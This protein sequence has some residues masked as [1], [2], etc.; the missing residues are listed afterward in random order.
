MR[1]KSRSFWSFRIVRIHAFER[2]QNLD[3]SGECNESVHCTLVDGASLIGADC[4]GFA[5]THGRFARF[6]AGFVTEWIGVLGPAPFRKPS[7]RTRSSWIDELRHTRADRLLA[8]HAASRFH[9]RAVLCVR[10]SQPNLGETEGK[11]PT[12]KP[13]MALAADQLM[14]SFYEKWQPVDSASA[15]Q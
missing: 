5:G 12:V 3:P 11:Y 2:P 8:E 1:T 10:R 7:R 6:E 4:N 13:L 14:M 9:S 15:T